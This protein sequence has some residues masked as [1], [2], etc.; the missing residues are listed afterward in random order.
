MIGDLRLCSRR[1]HDGPQ[2][3]IPVVC[4]ACV[5]VRKLPC[6]ITKANCESSTPF[7]L[8]EEHIQ[9]RRSSWFIGG[10][11]LV[12]GGATPV[13]ERVDAALRGFAQQRLS[14]EKAFSIP[15][16]GTEHSDRRCACRFSRSA[17]SRIWR[18][19]R[20]ALRRGRLRGRT[21]YPGTTCRRHRPIFC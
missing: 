14:F 15:W 9:R 21:D 12:D 1:T 16:C 17:R 11:E 6:G 4:T 7:L 13:P 2:K 5:S 8:R 19:S 20:R 18:C 10:R 3:H